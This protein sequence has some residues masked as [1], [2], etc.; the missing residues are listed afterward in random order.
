[1]GLKGRNSMEIRPTVLTDW[2]VRMWK[3]TRIGV[4]PHAVIHRFRTI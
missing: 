2:A 4:L 1:L 3:Y